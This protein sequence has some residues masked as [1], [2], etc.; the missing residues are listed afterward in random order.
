MIGQLPPSRSL[1]TARRYAARRQLEELVSRRGLFRRRRRIVT[2][3]V[4]VAIV[5]SGV[6]GITLL[7]SSPITDRSTARC[8]TVDSVGTG[9]DFVGTTI[10]ASGIPGSPAQV[11]N[12]IA[13]CADFWRQGFL[14]AGKTGIQRRP[15][16]QSN[17]VPPL[18][19]CTLPDGRAAIF[20][21]DQDTCAQ[22]GLPLAAQ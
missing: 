17:P 9:E 4:V 22:L 12:A 19:A 6:A 3:L 18:I 10:V 5:G 16:S 15:A 2:G 8:Y 7:R 1:P 13:V 21:G 11:D 20:P 14:V